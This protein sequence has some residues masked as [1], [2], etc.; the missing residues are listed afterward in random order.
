MHNHTPLDEFIEATERTPERKE[1]RNTVFIWVIILIIL[2]LAAY[3]ARHGYEYLTPPEP[4]LIG[5]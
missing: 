1:K 3:W 5:K 4:R 2:A